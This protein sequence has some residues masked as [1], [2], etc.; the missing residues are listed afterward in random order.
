M[1]SKNDIISN[2]N[3]ELIKFIS[4]FKTNNIVIKNFHKLYPYNLVSDEIVYINNINR[5]YQSYITTWDRDPD[6]VIITYSKAN[7]K[8]TN[9]AIQNIINIR[10]K[11]ETHESKRL[12]FYPGDRCCLDKPIDV[13]LIEK[14]DKIYYKLG[15]CLN[16]TLYNGEIFDIKNVENIKVKTFINKSKYIYNYFEGQILT[17]SRINDSESKTYDII[18]IDNSIIESAF[19][20]IRS[21]ESKKKYNSYLNSFAKQYPKLNYGYCTTVYKSQG[22]EWNNVLVNLNS[23]KWSI[24]KNDEIPNNKQKKTLFKTTYTAITRASKNIK[25]FWV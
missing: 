2:I 20:K 8:K 14:V 16:N 6:V 12:I 1:R 24:I 4:Y 9:L 17:I 22:S 25:L 10:E 5:F 23:I 3:A 15:E 7:C 11:H 13:H 18:H 21:K 19:K